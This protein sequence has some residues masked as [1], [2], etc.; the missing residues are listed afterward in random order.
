[1]QIEFSIQEIEKCQE[2]ANS[3]D[4]GYYANRKQFNNEKRIKDQ[5]IG[6]IAEIC[7]YKYLTIKNIDVSFP[8][9]AIYKRTGKNWNCDLK[10]QDY[11]FHIKSQS[12]EQGKRYGVSWIFE[13][14]DKTVFKNISDNGYVCFVSIDL[15]NRVGEIRAVVNLQDLH[16]HQLFQKPQLSYLTTKS[17]VYFDQ[18]EKTLGNNLLAI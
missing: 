9:F 3:I 8:D 15:N 14:S 18:L 10:S 2:F 17:A 6:K 16:K 1:M 4:T 11:E 13:N 5:I 7:A 12:I